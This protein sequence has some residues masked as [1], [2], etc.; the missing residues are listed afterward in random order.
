MPDIEPVSRRDFFATNAN[1]SWLHTISTDA[2][3]AKAGI[4]PPPANPTT[5]QLA[6]FWIKAEIAWRWR[7]ADLMLKGRD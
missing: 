7:Y 4:N 2:A 1:L 6:N 5:Q 3:A